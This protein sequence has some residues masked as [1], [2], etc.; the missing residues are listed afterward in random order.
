[1]HSPV[2]QRTGAGWPRC[3]FRTACVK[4]H[5]DALAPE[6]AVPSTVAGRY[7]AGGD[8][9]VTAGWGHFGAGEAVMPGRGR[10]VERAY[11]PEELKALAEHVVEL[12]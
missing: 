6:I 4:R 12:G 9:A 7:M 2:R 8:F 5:R 11:R 3:W 10:I 1:M